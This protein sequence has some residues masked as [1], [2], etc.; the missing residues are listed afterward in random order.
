MHPRN[1][2][3]LPVSHYAA[4][5]G[6]A[7]KHQD[8]AGLVDRDPAKG[9]P[10]FLTHGIAEPIVSRSAEREIELDGAI[11]PGSGGGQRPLSVDALGKILRLHKSTRDGR[12]FLVLYGDGDGNG[13]GGLSAE[14][15]C[16]QDF[17]HTGL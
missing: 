9:V 2:G 15:Q 8:I 6:R 14:P 13:E 10:V 17:L 5:L 1:G 16:E 4:A 11:C 7:A 12:A 3:A